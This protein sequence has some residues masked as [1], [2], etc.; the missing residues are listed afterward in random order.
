MK[1]HTPRTITKMC[2]ENNNNFFTSQAELAV[3]SDIYCSDFH[4]LESAFK[5]DN[6]PDRIPQLR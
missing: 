2:E 3:K 1:C 5:G 4:G 6:F